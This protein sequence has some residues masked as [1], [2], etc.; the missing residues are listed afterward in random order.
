MDDPSKVGD[1]EADSHTDD[2]PQ[3]FP[4][5]DREVAQAYAEA[6]K[7]RSEDDCACSDD[8]GD[9]TGDVDAVDEEIYPTDQMRVGE[10][11]DLPDDITERIKE[12]AGSDDDVSPTSGR[13]SEDGPLST[14]ERPATDTLTMEV[15]V[16]VSDFD[17]RDREILAALARGYEDSFLEVVEKSRSYGFAFIETGNEIASRPSGQFSNPVRASANGLFHRTGDKRA[18]F[19]RRM[20]GDVK[21][22]TEDP[23]PQTA[24]E[25]GNYWMLLSFLVSHP[26]LV[27]D[28]IEE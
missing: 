20:F 24:R 3:V 7:A 21:D 12:I 26:D 1:D 15:T 28:Y 19:Y 23:V 11:D 14:V 5:S 22:T 8:D 25:C 17:E 4:M 13:E 6:V 18:R 9:T 2:V 10:D 27:S 16:D